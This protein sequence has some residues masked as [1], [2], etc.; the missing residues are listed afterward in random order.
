MVM[1]KHEEKQGSLSR[2]SVSILVSA[3]LLLASGA[4]VSAGNAALVSRVSPVKA[5]SRN[6]DGDKVLHVMV[7]KTVVLDF[8]DRAKRVAVANKNVADVVI[9]TP[10][11]LLV[12]GISGGETSLVVWSGKG[13]YSIYNIVV[14]EQAREQ[15]MLEIMIAE[16]NK[17]ELE[18]RGIDIRAMG[19]QFGVLSQ[20]GGAAPVFGQHAPQTNQPPFP[21]S[22]GSG[23]S[24]AVV[25]FRNDIAGFIKATNDDNVARI[26]AE[27]KLLARSGEKASFLSG[28]EI[29]ILISE[30]QQTSVSYKEFGVKVEFVPTVTIDGTI[31]LDVFAEVSEPDFSQGVELFGFTVPAFVSRRAQTSVSLSS[32]RSLVIAGLL[33]T[34][35]RDFTSK[36]PILGSVPILGAFFRRSEKEKFETELIMVVKPVLLGPD[37]Q[38]ASAAASQGDGAVDFIRKK[39]EGAKPR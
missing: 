27:P 34:S 2:F 29:P 30:D 10:E 1:Q 26:L 21:V 6:G 14:T 18:K 37:G 11:Q 5:A 36:V 12:N 20:A 9:A 24:L 23:L 17:A 32:G 35:E 31:D 25:D 39:T 19:G 28:G 22:L 15:V 16:V 33:K 3:A 13:N 4:P 7:G 8:R 38:D